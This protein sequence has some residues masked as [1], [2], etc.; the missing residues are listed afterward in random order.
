VGRLLF[1]GIGI[2][3]IAALVLS[4]LVA[5]HPW[6]FGTGFA[7]LAVLAWI[8]RKHRPARVFALDVRAM[9]PVEYEQFCAEALRRAGWSVRH[10]GGLGDQGVDVIAELRGIRAAVQCK[11]YSGRAGNDAVQQ[12]VAGKRHYGAQIAVVVAPFGYTR[13][14][15]QLAHSN[16][17]LLMS[18]SDL[19]SL[20][21]VARVP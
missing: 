5:K 7:V 14:A 16:A 21:R 13:A 4:A 18:H 15:E 8:G 20:E 17:A 10:V 2:I 1:G 11:R 6:E 9:S 12:V 3:C 19:A